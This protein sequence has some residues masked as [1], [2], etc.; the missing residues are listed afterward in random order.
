LAAGVV[1]A[2]GAAAQAQE[3]DSLG[4]GWSQQQGEVRQGVRQRELIPLLRVIQEIQRRTPGRQL[5][6][7]LEQMG[8]R[9]VYRVRW[10]T[11]DGRRID[12]MVDATT[13]AILSGN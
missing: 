12:Y 4:A 13:G 9:A 6:A 7:G 1:L 3:P 5:D 10:M 2:V 8:A 11:S